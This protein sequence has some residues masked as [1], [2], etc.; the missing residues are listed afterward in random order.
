VAKET[1][2]RL[3][4]MPLAKLQGAKRNP[5]THDGGA[6][7]DSVGRFGFVEPIV[8]DERTGRLVAGHGRMETLREMRKVGGEPPAG[9]EVGQKGEWLVP[10]VRGWKSKNDAE[11]EAYLIA[12]NRIV[13]VG[14]W[15]DSMLAKML[16][17]FDPDDLLGTGFGMG[18]VDAMLRDLKDEESATGVK[19]GDRFIVP[20]FS[21]LDARQGYWQERKRAW[22]SLGIQSEIGRGENLLSFS[23][24]VQLKKKV[25]EGAFRTKASGHVQQT[26]TSIFDPVL[27][28]LA[29]RWF[30]KP[31]FSVLDPFAGGSVRGIIA[32]KLGLNYTGVE[33]RKEQVEAN[34]AQAKKICEK[35]V[36]EWINGDSTVVLPNL[37]GTESYDLIFSCPPYMDLEVYSEDPRDLS[38][39]EPAAFNDL[40]RTIISS[41]VELLKPNRFAVFVVG[42][43]REQRT[44]FYR[45]FVPETIRAFETAGAKLYNEAILV[46]SVGSLPM[47]VGNAFPRGRKLG[48]THQNVLVFFKGDPEQIVDELGEL[49]IPPEALAMAELE[50][51]GEESEYGVEM[52]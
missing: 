26:G 16:S 51:A 8:L 27:C 3:E 25:S 29:Y 9:V 42:E 35:P 38:T 5:K 13:E 44:G 37:N 50:V 18:D 19:L 14:G 39:M 47:R 36:P 15:D 45:G 23:K 20:P 22:L 40:Y 10:V 30:A 43:V 12:S 2:R 7:A 49:E 34:R 48:K 32:S 52:S 21:V 1:A 17:G 31:G 11:A 28:E 24:T 33:L 6:L 4:L 46:T 41:A